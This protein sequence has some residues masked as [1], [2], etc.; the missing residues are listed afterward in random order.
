PPPPPPPPPPSL[1]L[2]SWGFGEGEKK[3]TWGVE[4]N[5]K[6]RQKKPEGRGTLHTLE[7]T[8]TTPDVLVM[9]VDHNQFK[10]VSGDS[11]TQAFIVDTK[12]VWR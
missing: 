2:G 1:R 6:E 8:L 5:I 9:L 10:A 12:G 3:K 11:V 7:A 4:P